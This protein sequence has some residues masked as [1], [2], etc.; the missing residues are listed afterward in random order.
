VVLAFLDPGSALEIQ[1][2]VITVVFA[3]VLLV[4]PSSKDKQ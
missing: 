3:F 1:V 4:R 2:L